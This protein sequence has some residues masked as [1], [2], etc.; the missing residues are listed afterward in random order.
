M[1]DVRRFIPENP[2]VTEGKWKG[3]TDIYGTLK[4]VLIMPPDATATYDVGIK[5]EGDMLV[6]VRY[7][8]QGVLASENLNIILFPG[9]KEIIIENASL[10]GPFRVKL[11]YQM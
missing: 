3:S 9:E 6:Y 4:Q 5:D 10:S 1:K 2:V 11:I 7:G 8:I